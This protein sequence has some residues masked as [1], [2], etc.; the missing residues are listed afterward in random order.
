MNV[1]IDTQCWLWWFSDEGRLNAEARD[2]IARGD[3]S[4]YFS[5]ASSWEIAI[6][7]SIGKLKLPETPDR[8][9][10]G[11]LASQGML[12]M[13]VEH[14]HALRVASLPDLH[15]DPFDRLLVA[16]SQVESMA[17]LTADP[18]IVAY[19]VETIWAGRGPAPR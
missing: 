2:L 12:G 8:Y 4:I 13:A 19:D 14:A 15:R 17:L 16:Q 18:L 6:K 1:L 9:V 7:C 10:P 11:R 5:A 3:N